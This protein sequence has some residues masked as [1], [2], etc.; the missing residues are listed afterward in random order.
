MNQ[1]EASCPLTCVAISISA[2]SNQ[3]HIYHYWSSCGHPP[4]LP[5]HQPPLQEKDDSK[6]N[7]VHCGREETLEHD[8]LSCPGSRSARSVRLF[9]SLG[10][11]PPTTIFSKYALSEQLT[12]SCE[13]ASPSSLSLL[14]LHSSL[15][16]PNYA[17]TFDGLHHFL[18]GLS[19]LHLLV[20]SLLL[21]EPCSSHPCSLLC[22]PIHNK[23]L[24]SNK[25]SQQNKGERWWTGEAEW[26]EEEEEEEWWWARWKGWRRWA[27]REIRWKWNREIM[28]EK[29]KQNL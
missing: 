27:M 11:E 14:L 23:T 12:T 10:F 4:P 25:W 21:L 3:T 5:T 6:P 19:L 24:L 7:C 15:K 13:G 17:L 22:E 1:D 9:S 28:M 29:V 26:W 20:S 16:L 8:I 18:V 2:L